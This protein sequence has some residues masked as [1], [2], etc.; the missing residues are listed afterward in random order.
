MRGVDVE[1]K[2]A[3]YRLVREQADAGRTFIW[4]TTEM[5][6]LLECDHCYVFRGGQVVR[7]LT[8]DQLD[9]AS[10][11]DASFASEA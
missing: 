3:V 5:E 9:H 1:T 10:V 6:E 11:L 8:R 2:H 4:Y 7:E